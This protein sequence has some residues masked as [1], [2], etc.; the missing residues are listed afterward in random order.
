VDYHYG[1]GR[2]TASQKL[3]YKDGAHDIVAVDPL[4]RPP[5]DIELQEEFQALLAAEKQCTADVRDVEK[6]V[7]DIVNNRNKEEQ[8]INLVTPYYDVV[9]VKQEESDDEGD[10]DEEAVEHDYLSPFLPVLIA[11]KSMTKPESMDVRERCL[12]GLKD[13]LIE[14]ANIIQARNTLHPELVTKSPELGTRNPSCKSKP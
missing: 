6:E 3:F 12:K 1:A 7:K 10:K 14:R 8:N 9:R 13:R 2:V 11:G 4:A 5:G